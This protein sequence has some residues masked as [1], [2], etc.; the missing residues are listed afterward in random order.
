MHLFHSEGHARRLGGCKTVAGTLPARRIASVYIAAR[1]VVPSSW[2]WT[3]GVISSELA[4]SR[5]A[6]IAKEL[7][8]IPCNPPFRSKQMNLAPSRSLSPRPFPTRRSNQ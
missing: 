8:Q 4:L 3:G 2:S 7:P 5:R 6:I 1:L